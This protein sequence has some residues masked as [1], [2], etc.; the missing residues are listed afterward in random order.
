MKIRT[1]T[2][3]VAI[4]ALAA[5]SLACG[6]VTV[7]GGI[8]P[9]PS[10]PTAVPAQP[11]Q[12]P[13]PTAAP[14]VEQPTLAAAPDLGESPTGEY[15]EYML[16]TDDAGALQMEV[17]T[18]WSEVDGSPWVEQDIV[19]G[20]SIWA[21]PNLVDFRDTW[22]TPG[23]RFEASDDLAT[24]GGYV[25]LLDGRRDYY[26]SCKLEARYDYSDS[27]YRGKYDWYNYCGGTTGG[28]AIV[29]SAVP[30]DNPG[31]YLI[32]IQGQMMTQA[33]VDAMQRVLDTFVVVGALP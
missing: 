21:A 30:F 11:T 19:I 7:E 18:A 1:R 33:D 29:L 12:P 17:P 9:F 16:V 28:S 6:T 24:L 2:P 8:T 13:A 23:V 5:L 27:L 26:S 3:I 31:A 4:I 25:Q 10:Q 32:L 14:P 20:A 15:T 22:T